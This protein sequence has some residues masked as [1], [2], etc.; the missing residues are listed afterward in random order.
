MPGSAASPVVLDPFRTITEVGWNVVT[1]IAISVTAGQDFQ[2]GTVAVPLPPDPG[3][4]SRPVIPEADWYNTWRIVPADYANDVQFVGTYTHSLDYGS[5]PQPQSAYIWRKF[6]AQ[7]W[8]VSPSG[9]AQL[10]DITASGSYDAQTELT[11]PSYGF[12]PQGKWQMSPGGEGD[13]KH[14]P[15]EPSLLFASDT[16][17]VWKYALNAIWTESPYWAS[18]PSFSVGFGGYTA[19]QEKVLIDKVLPA[20]NVIARYKGQAFRGCATALQVLGG[21][22]EVLWILC[23]RSPA[24]D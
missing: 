19:A 22:S 6:D 15:G 5:G 9:V 8:Q 11:N 23:K 16:A 3:L 17:P 21:G 4:G 12:P 2:D 7:W 1:H 24:D 10:P 18:G 14:V 13:G 20:G